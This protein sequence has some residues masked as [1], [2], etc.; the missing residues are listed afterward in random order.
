MFCKDLKSLLENAHFENG[1]NLE[2]GP[3]I[4]KIT[5]SAI[6]RH[7]RLYFKPNVF[8]SQF[9]QPSWILHFVKGSRLASLGFFIST[10]WRC[11]SIKTLCVP[12]IWDIWFTARL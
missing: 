5:Y 9:W 1:N 3:L 6:T 8:C 4:L 10:K 12:I 11:K 7:C 2:F